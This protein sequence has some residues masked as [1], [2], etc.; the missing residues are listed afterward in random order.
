VQDEETDLCKTESG[1]FSKCASLLNHEMPGWD[2]LTVSP[3]SLFELGIGYRVFFAFFASDYVNIP[4]PGGRLRL[5][6]GI[7]GR[8]IKELNTHPASPQ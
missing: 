5:E 6:E 1:W 7:E 3:L 4:S 8:G 2:R